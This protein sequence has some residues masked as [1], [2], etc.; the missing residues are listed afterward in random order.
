MGTNDV[1]QNIAD[2]IDGFYQN[3]DNPCTL[4]VRAELTVDKVKNCHFVD[5]HSFSTSGGS[6]FDSYRFE[7]RPFKF[8]DSG[9]KWH[10]CS[11]PVNRF[12][13]QAI[14]LFLNQHVTEY[15]TYELPE[16]KDSYYSVQLIQK[17]IETLKLSVKQFDAMS[18]D[19]EYAHLFNNMKLDQYQID[20]FV[21]V[22][23]GVFLF[24][25]LEGVENFLHDIIQNHQFIEVNTNREQIYLKASPIYSEMDL[26]VEITKVSQSQNRKLPWPLQHQHYF[27]NS[28]CKFTECLT[29]NSNNKYE[30]INSDNLRMIANKYNALELKNP[31]TSRTRVPIFTMSDIFN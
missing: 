22:S 30:N 10:E 17:Q 9:M 26:I 18:K 28:L 3:I 7:I 2:V 21:E 8:S 14:E 15:I 31:I 25:K 19:P 4:T 20:D 11:E 13:E 6:N 16:V 5:V 23:I 12:F 1:F 29:T 24:D 27:F